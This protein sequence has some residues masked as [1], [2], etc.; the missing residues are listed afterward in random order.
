M[1][2]FLL[3][4]FSATL[5]LVLCDVIGLFVIGTQSDLWPPYDGLG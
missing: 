2:E 4:I 1:I 3:C 5:P